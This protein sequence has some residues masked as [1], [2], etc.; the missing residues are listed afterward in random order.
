MRLGIF[1]ILIREMSE[2]LLKIAEQ[3]AAQVE[4]LKFSLPIH[5]IYNPLVYAK[6][7]HFD[8]LSKY[9]IGRKKVVFMGMNPGPWGMS[10][11]GV[12][13]GEIAAVKD[14][15]KIAGEVKKPKKEHPKRKI[16]GFE[17]KKSEVSGRRLWGL[18]KDRFGKPDHFFKNHFVLNYCPLVF[19]EESGRNFTPDKLPAG[20]Q[21]PLMEY[22]DQHL[23]R[24]VEI[25]D[26]EWVVGVG[27]YAAGR[28][29]SVLRNT[30]I[31]VD[32]VLHPSPASPA[33]NRDW[34]GQA[35]QKLE[36]LGIWQ[37]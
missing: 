28:A 31:K 11:T 2:K 34:S 26:P 7:S 27:K 10:Q 30:D 29:E 13:F 20:E 36:A 12:P 23:K 24:V 32:W 3:L 33:A 25:L 6:A 17:C 35:T 1:R 5:T 37:K 9:G 18:F 22:C 8:Y 16:E 15:L 4:S 19:M 14:W 21:K